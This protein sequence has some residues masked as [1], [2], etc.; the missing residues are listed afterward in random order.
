MSLDGNPYV[1]PESEG[2]VQLVD[3]LLPVERGLQPVDRLPTWDSSWLR[4]PE[5]YNLKQKINT[6]PTYHCET[7]SKVAV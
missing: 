6:P 4:H 3:D 7:K 1:T 5:S 2:V